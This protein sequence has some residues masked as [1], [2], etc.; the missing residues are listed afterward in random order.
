MPIPHNPLGYVR[1]YVLEAEGGLILVDPGWDDPDPYAVLMAG[2]AAIGAVP[3]DISGVVV[4]HYHPDHGGL[5]GRI[6]QESGAWVAM[7]PADAN[8][9]ASVARPLQGLLVRR[10]FG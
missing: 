5:A 3:A 10:R 1:C 2:L 9:I 4:T 7:H 8:R 6:R